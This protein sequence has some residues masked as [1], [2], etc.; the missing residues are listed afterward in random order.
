MFPV[1]QRCWGRCAG[2][3]ICKVKNLHTFVRLPPSKQG[4]QDRVAIAMLA[5]SSIAMV[6]DG[7]LLHTVRL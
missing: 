1:S 6:E 7:S 2:K 3:N 5:G 4:L